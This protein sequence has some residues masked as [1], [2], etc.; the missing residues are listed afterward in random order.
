MRQGFGRKHLRFA[1]PIGAARIAASAQMI[2]RCAQSRSQAPMFEHVT[3]LLSFVYALAVSHLLTSATELMWARERVRM[4][5]LQALWMF[6]ALLI[7][8]ENWIGIWSLSARKQWDVAEIT[9]YF[10]AALIQYFTCSLISLRPREEGRIDMVASF[11]RQRP[12]IFGAFFVL[13]AMN[14]FQNWWDGAL[15]D[16]PLG[17]LYAD[18]TIIVLL[19]AYAIAGFARAAWLQ[20][21]AA[22][23]AAAE[24]V[25]WL[26]RFAI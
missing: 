15:G 25:F 13:A 20:W 19:A 3:I 24:A 23:A 14:M 4:S 8:F 18:I 22:I 11:Q 12:L 26:I 10:V 7:L 1:W 21:L 5:G 17:W 9:I 2:P 16:E 6:N